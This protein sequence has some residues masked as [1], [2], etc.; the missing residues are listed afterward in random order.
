MSIAEGRDRGGECRSD[1]D[2]GVGEV[3]EEM[4]EEEKVIGD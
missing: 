3:E 2:S 4:E 1:P